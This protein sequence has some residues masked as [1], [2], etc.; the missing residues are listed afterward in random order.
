MNGLG[1]FV[2]IILKPNQ[3]QFDLIRAGHVVGREG[4]PL[5][6]RE[7]DLDLVQLTGVDR[8]RRPFVDVITRMKSAPGG[9]ATMQRTVVEKLIGWTVRLLSHDRVDQTLKRFDHGRRLRATMNTVAG[10]IP[11]HHVGECAASNVSVIDFHDLLKYNQ[12]VNTS[13]WR[14]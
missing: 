4:R 6:K 14:A 12:I 5:N 9:F 11:S 2:L 7:P 3:S 1:I 8:R 10:Y 13:V